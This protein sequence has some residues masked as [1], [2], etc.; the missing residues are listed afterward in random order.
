VVNKWD[1]V[2]KTDKTALDYEKHLDKALGATKYIPYVFTSA[3][4]KQRVAKVLETA[5]KV[6][7]ERNRTIATAQL[8]RFLERIIARN[9]PP[10]VRGKEIKLN[11]A[12]QIK[13]R[14]PVFAIF[15]NEPT[16]IPANYRQYIENQMRDEFGFEG[17]PLSLTFRKKSRDRYE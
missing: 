17:V 10:A 15:S 11:Y 14:P 3:L 8:N 5:K 13:S 1:L 7:D 4:T 12:T 6:H 2:K 9:H 16:L